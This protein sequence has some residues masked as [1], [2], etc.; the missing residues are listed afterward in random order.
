MIATASASRWDSR[1]IRVALRVRARATVYSLADGD[2]SVPR[3]F[4]SLFRGTEVL[5]AFRLG[6]SPRRL[7]HIELPL[8]LR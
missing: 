4:R 6:D 3:G 1:A 5:T 8:D 2:V 7:Q